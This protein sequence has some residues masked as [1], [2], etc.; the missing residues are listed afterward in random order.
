LGG[1]QVFCYRSKCLYTINK[2]I[3]I[4]LYWGNQQWD[5]S[6]RPFFGFQPTQIIVQFSWKR[7]CKQNFWKLQ[8]WRIRRQNKIIYLIIDFL[9]ISDVF[10]DNGKTF[11]LWGTGEKNASIST[12]GSIFKIG[13]LFKLNEIWIR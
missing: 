9:K 12:M 5:G 11:L 7:C 1:C 4:S 2:Y 3:N 13:R 10:E 8:T 6:N